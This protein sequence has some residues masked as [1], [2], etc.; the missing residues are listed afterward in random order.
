MPEIKSRFIECYIYVSTPIGIKYLLLKRHNDNK[1]YSG[2][3]QIVT[4]RI[5]KNEKAYDAALRELKE[6]TGLKVLKFFVIPKITPFYTHENDT[7]NLIPLFLAE[8][9]Y[10]EVKISNE[11]SEYLWCD[12]KDAIKKVYWHSQKENLKMISECLGNEKFRST[13]LEIELKN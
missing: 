7:I 5:E 8:V 3:W 4:G 13:L 2:I 11:H 1:I 10:D 6:E 12:V 9:F